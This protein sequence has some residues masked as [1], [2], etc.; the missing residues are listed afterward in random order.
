MAAVTEFNP[1]LSMASEMLEARRQRSRS[2]LFHRLPQPVQRFQPSRLDT[3]LPLPRR[4]SQG[5]DRRLGALGP[6]GVLAAFLK[7]NTRSR[8]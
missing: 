1:L 3:D 8:V 2:S 6:Q 4:P 5:P 7:G